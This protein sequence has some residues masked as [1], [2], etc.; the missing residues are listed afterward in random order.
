MKQVITFNSLRRCSLL[1]P[2]RENNAIKGD[3]FYDI[4]QLRYADIKNGKFFKLIKTSTYPAVKLSYF[5]A[6]TTDH[7]EDNLL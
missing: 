2:K 3:Q 4:Q 1:T 5:A 6:L 7:G